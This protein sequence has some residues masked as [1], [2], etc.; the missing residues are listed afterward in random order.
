MTTLITGGAGFIGSHL[1]DALIARGETVH[2][3]DDLSTGSRHNIQQL[4][5]HERFFFTEGS[6]CDRAITAALVGKCDRVYHLA[7]AVGVKRIVADP[8]A[9]IET[10]VHGTESVLSACAEHRCRILITSSSEIYGKNSLSGALTEDDGCNIGP[11]HI[12]RWSYACTKILDEFLALSYHRTRDLPVIITRLFNVIG[13]RQVGSYGMVVPT[14]VGQALRGEPMTVYG[15]GTQTR[16]FVHVNDCIRA[17]IGLMDRPEA[18]G[19]AFNVGGDQEI[20]IGDLARLIKKTTASSSPIVHI[21]YKQAYGKDFEDLQRRVPHLG[22]IRQEI[23]YT[24]RMTLKDAIRDITV[25]LS[26]K[27]DC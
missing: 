25:G 22:R 11:T 10:N 1:A 18:T 5:G 15:D 12:P 23:G 14:L 7:A 24:P 21:P 2:V 27:R 13:P 3:L 20:T 8:L 17:L 4:I 9:A 16:T 6:V 26:E 19:R